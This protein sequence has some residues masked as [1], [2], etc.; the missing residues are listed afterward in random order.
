M[1]AW[2]D[3]WNG[4]DYTGQFDGLISHYDRA[5]D[6]GG[7]AARYAIFSI[8]NDGP[9]GNPAYRGA[10]DTARRNY[11]LTGVTSD[12]QW[13]EPSG[14][15]SPGYIFGEFAENVAQPTVGAW[16][17]LTSWLYWFKVGFLGF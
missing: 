7:D 8:L 15:S 11:G 9:N 10:L 3:L 1:T 6:F 4:P 5:G 12:P 2:S 14:W 17:S 16:M 13:S